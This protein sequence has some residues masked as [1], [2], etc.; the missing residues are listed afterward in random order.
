[1]HVS[2]FLGFFIFSLKNFMNFG[3]NFSFI[4]WFLTGSAVTAWLAVHL[5][6]AVSFLAWWSNLA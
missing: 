2:S 6:S 1:M 4:F 5:S 3:S